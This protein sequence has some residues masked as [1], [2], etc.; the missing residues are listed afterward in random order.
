MS[1]GDKYKAEIRCL[2]CGH[3]NERNISKGITIKDYLKF[4]ASDGD[5]KCDKCECNI[6][7]RGR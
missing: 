1:D 2:N 4:E 7:E 5:E 6:R 3:E